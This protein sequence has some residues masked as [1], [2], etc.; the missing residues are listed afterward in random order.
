MC[1][2]SSKRFERDQCCYI[3]RGI[4]PPSNS[5]SESPTT[6]LEEEG[7]QTNFCYTIMLSDAGIGTPAICIRRAA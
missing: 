2:A 4:R 5:A 6:A 3:R 7:K 1:S